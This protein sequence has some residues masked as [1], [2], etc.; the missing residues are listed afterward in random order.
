M[1]SMQLELCYN[2]SMKPTKE[3]ILQKLR[4]L[5]PQLKAEGIEHIALF[6]SYANENATPYSDIDIAI[7]KNETLRTTMD[8]YRYFELLASVRE[9]L[10]QTFHRKVD[11]FDLDSPS[12]FKKQIQ[13]ELIYA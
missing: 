12:P 6:G 8:A 10:R 13:S 11:I 3:M 5:K 4:E 1:D 7:A 9:I 2:T